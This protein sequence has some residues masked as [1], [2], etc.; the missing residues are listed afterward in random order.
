MNTDV[1]SF[2]MTGE[3]HNRLQLDDSGWLYLNATVD[4]E[5]QA[6]YT[7]QIEGLNGNQ[8]VVEGPVMVIIIIQDINDNQPI[9]TEKEYQG[10]VWQNSRPG[11]PFMEVEATDLDDPKTPNGKIQYSI[12]QQIP[13][14]DNIPYFQIDKETGAISTTEQG[15]EL[16]DP[17]QVN[18]YELV[19]AA[20]DL[21]ELSLSKNVV[22]KIEVKENLW[23]SPGKIE[24]VENSTDPHP[25]TITKVQWNKPGAI[26]E[27]KQKNKMIYP[28]FPFVVDANGDINVTEPLDREETSEYLLLVYALDKNRE[29]LEMPLEIV[30]DVKDINDNKP[31]C[32]KPVTFLEVQENEKRGSDIGSVV[33]TDNDEEGT[34]NSMLM[35]KILVQEPKIPQDNMF[36]IDD[37]QGVIQRFNGNLEKKNA[38]EYTLI[39][40]VTD[41]MGSDE[42]LSTECIVN[43]SVIDIND[44]IPIFE[45]LQYGTI[46]IQENTSLDTVLIEIQAT[47]DDESLTGSSEI[48]YNVVGGDDNGTFKIITEEQTNK[49]LVQLAKPLDFETQSFYMLNI[50]ATNPE[51]LVEG[52]YYNSSSFTSLFVN[53]TDTDEPPQFLKASYRQ[54]IFENTSIGDSVLTVEAYDPE[55]DGVRYQLTYDPRKWFRMDPQSG[56]IFIREKLDAEKEKLYTIMATAMEKGDPTK[57]STVHIYI[58]LLDVNDNPPKL[59]K[60]FNSFFMCIPA[61]EEKKVTILAVDDDIQQGPP[62]T[63]SINQVPGRNW[64]IN[65]IN[66]SYA[67]ITMKFA[68]HEEETEYKIPVTIFD[69][70]YPPLHATSFMTV[71]VCKCTDSKVCIIPIDDESTYSKVGLAVGILLGTL[72]VIGLILL[73][74]FLKMKQKKQGKAEVT[75]RLDGTDKEV[76]PLATA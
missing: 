47:D 48:L 2:R 12:I 22:V 26:F 50:S 42:G 17:Q 7:L 64:K 25:K 1:K 18:E 69:S 6:N 53:V 57:K 8:E 62:F 76:I 24:V 20:K 72:A 56:E 41:E 30:V 10:V 70:G 35:Y 61:D 63:F 14:I 27:L 67:S 5:E 34:R 31:V 39:I 44:K 46:T 75:N 33:A 21:A 59:A 32:A 37:F 43:I 4:R 13:S 36:Q 74:V 45:N 38:P 28:R 68:K 49:G 52:V 16:L 55:G 71:K 73:V 3:T 66:D 51:P 15:Y 11:K 58:Q 23:K 65:P 54:W 9:F 60:D 29:Q 40:Q 19:V